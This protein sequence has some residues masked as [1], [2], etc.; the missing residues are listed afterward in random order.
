MT[1]QA[2]IAKLAMSNFTAVIE[3][4]PQTGL[5]VGFVPGFPGVHSQAETLDELDRNL[6]EV[7]AMLL[8]D[9]EPRFESEFVEIQTVAVEWTGAASRYCVISLLS[10]EEEVLTGVEEIERAV[11]QLSPDELVRFRRWFSEFDSVAWDAQIEADAAAGKFDALAEE[12]L[13]EYRVGKARG[14]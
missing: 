11:A 9:D 1:S 5:L 2:E 6:R 4:C 8:E 13:A 12:A 3:R 10:G 14:I 7:I